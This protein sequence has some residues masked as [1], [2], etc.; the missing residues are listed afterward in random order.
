M[1]Q[2]LHGS[3][4]MPRPASRVQILYTLL[5][6]ELEPFL[7]ATRPCTD[8]MRPMQQHLCRSTLAGWP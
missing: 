4:R 2:V 1:K 3:H 7:V 5:A 8:F 6:V